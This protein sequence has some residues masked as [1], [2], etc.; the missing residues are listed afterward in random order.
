VKRKRR[1]R[2]RLGVAGLRRGRH[3]PVAI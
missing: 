2:L 1:T 3:R